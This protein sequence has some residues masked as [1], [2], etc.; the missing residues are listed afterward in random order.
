LDT[1]DGSD[2]FLTVPGRTIRIKQQFSVL[3]QV[4]EGSGGGTGT[5]DWLDAEKRQIRD[6][7]GVDGQKSAAIDGQLQSLTSMISAVPGTMLD[8][9]VSDHQNPGSL[10][11]VLQR[12]LNIEAGRWKIVDNEMV[13]YATDNETEVA[14]FAL[15]DA[16][17]KPTMTEVFERLV[18]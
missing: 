14:R 8:Q 12:L 13:F 5:S 3:T 15:L 1:E 17:G 16:T 7:L 10:G 6:A 11:Y 18:L 9:L 4:V 2:P